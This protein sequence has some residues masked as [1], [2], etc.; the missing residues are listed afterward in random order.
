MLTTICLN[1]LSC[2]AL[3]GN[4][5]ELRIHKSQVLVSKEDSLHK[6]KELVVTGKG[7]EHTLYGTVYYPKPEIRKHIGN[8]LELL[9]HMMLPQ[10]DVHLKEKKVMHG[11]KEVTLK[12]NG[13]VVN[14]NTE[15]LELQ[16][17]DIL[18]IEF[19]EMPTGMDAEY[20]AVINYV[21]RRYKLGGYVMFDGEQRFKGQ[22]D[23]LSMVRMSHNLSE[24]TVGYQ[25]SYMNNPWQ[26]QRNDESWKYPDALV[27]NRQTDSYASLYKK[28]IHNVFVNYDYQKSGCDI[29]LNLGYK[30]NVVPHNDSRSS[31][32]YKGKYDISSDASDASRETYRNPYLSF[33]FDRTFKSGQ[34]LK[35]EANA[36]YSRN[37][38]NR[39]YEE[40]ENGGDASNLRTQINE[41]YLKTY[42]KIA[43][44]RSFPTGWNLS[45]TTGNT[46]S[47]S[48][49]YYAGSGEDNL[50]STETWLYPNVSK[51]WEHVFLSLRLGGKYQYYKQGNV[52]KHFIY[53]APKFIFRYLPSE[54][55]ILQYYFFFG[56]FAPAVYLYNS[57]LQSIDFLQKKIGNPRLAI[58]KEYENNLTYTANFNHFSLYYYL[59]QYSAFPTYRESVLYD[60]TYFIHSYMNTGHW[61]YLDTH[62][63]LGYSLLHDRLR[64]KMKLGIKRTES[65]GENSMKVYYAYISPIVNFYFKRFALQFYYN[66]PSKGVWMEN[67]K[68]TE[69][70]N[71]GLSFSYNTNNLSVS[72]STDTPLSCYKRTEALLQDIYSYD[73]IYHDG[74]Q[75]HSFYLNLTYHLSFG[76]KH[77]YKTIN[78]NNNTNSAIMK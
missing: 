36:D 69:T 43:W 25:F 21:V 1:V 23:Y 78:T 44:T 29:N 64:L 37:F 38:Y 70:G 73:K 74:L 26:Q 62:L 19:Q 17:K 16:P 32:S 9:A 27:L 24:Y 55:H 8:G 53:P 11:D 7:Q 41:D 46:V 75:E 30:N 2:Y 51:K 47:I 28:R 20:N 31:L 68:W 22:G 77:N 14:D 59:E 40:L 65:S 45:V 52:T 34:E 71:Y 5:G 10:I 3:R 48:N 50:F 33:S 56:N 67:V 63:V 61:N 6:L 72:L 12:I 76:R 54:N 60:G 57:T 35:V 13:R 42:A 49:K 4:M 66:S 39:S 18:R 15:I 58:R